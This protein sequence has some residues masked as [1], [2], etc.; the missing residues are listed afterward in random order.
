MKKIIHNPS[1]FV[2]ESI[3]GLIKSHPDVYALAKDNNRVVTRTKKASN[4]VG[5]VT[6][7]GSGHLPVFTGYVGKGFLDACA[8][9]SVFASP[10]VEQM[11]S[12][13]RNANN[14]KGVLCVLGNYGGD[15]MNFEMACE[16]TG[17]EGI[18]TKTVIVADDIASASNEE[19]LKRRGIAGMI[20]GFKIAGSIAETGASLEETFNTASS[21]NSNIRT[22]GVAVSQCILP[23]AGKPTFEIS[24]DEILT[25]SGSAYPQSAVIISFENIDTRDLEKTRVITSNFNGEWSFEEEINRTDVFWEKYVIFKNNQ[26]KT[27]KNLTIKSDYTIQVFASAVRYNLGETISITGKCEPNVNTTLWIKDPN[28]KIIHY[29]IFTTNANGDLNYQFVVDDTFSSGTYTVIIKQENGSDAALFGIGQYPATVLV[30]LMEKTN[31]ELNSKAV[32]SIVGPASSNLSISVLDS[33]D[34][35][36]MTDSITSSSIGKNK[37]AIDLDGLDSGVYRA[38]VSS[39]NIQDSVKFSI[40]L[41]S[42]SGPISLVATQANYS[43]GESIFIIGNTG[44]NARII[45]TLL[46]PSGNVSAITET[47]SDSTGGFSTTDIGIP[48]D[49]ALG[50]WKITAHNRLD[51]NNVEIN[52]SIPTGKSLT[53][54]SDETQFAIGDTIIIKG[55]GQSDS[56]RLEI[57]ITNESGEEIISLHTPITSSG[58]F[59]LPWTVPAGFD[60]GIYTITVSD[61]ENS[62]SL[63]IFIQ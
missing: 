3:D 49:G 20:F 14:G 23:E 21:A 43:A 22:L 31:F 35:I 55:V 19:K 56:N 59:S 51:N 54:Q 33:N 41:E 13:I 53:L 30:A 36:E 27:T 32:L 1:D 24:D 29:D 45:I 37:Y 38:V 50:N 46:D 61:D 8:I 5:I 7:G 52:V 40:G 17:S 44:S 48:S 26:D 11:A 4:K 16:I 6:G 10:S 62:S 28:K 60:T 12:A 18:K 34:N 2:E 42:A 57:K 58:A 9:G 39:I 15:V 47:F 63:E 25:F